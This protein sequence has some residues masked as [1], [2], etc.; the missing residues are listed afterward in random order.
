MKIINF[1]I[2]LIVLLL[3]LIPFLQSKGLVIS[4]LPKDILVY[5]IA[6]VVLG[7]IIIFLSLKGKKYKHVKIKQ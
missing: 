5:Q 2:G 7:A 3:G 1:V 6:S 4:F